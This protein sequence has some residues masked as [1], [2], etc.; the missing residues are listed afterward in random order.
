MDLRISAFRRTLAI[1][2]IYLAVAA[3]VLDAAMFNSALPVVTRVLEVE[4][5]DAIWVVNGY[6]A[7]ILVTLLFFSVIAE[8][9][10][11]KRVFITGLLIFIIASVVSSLSCS[12]LE[13]AMARGLLGVGASALTSI[14]LAMIQGFYPSCFA[15]RAFGFSACVVGLSMSVGPVLASIVLDAWSWTYLFS[16]N[17][18]IA[19]LALVLASWALPCTKPGLQRPS[20]FWTLLCIPAFSRAIAVSILAYASQGMSFTALPFVLYFSLSRSTAELGFVMMLWSLMA[21][22]TAPMSAR[23]SESTYPCLLRLG[24][25]LMSFGQGFIAFLPPYATLIHMAWCIALA[26]AGFGLFQVPNIC[27]LL[28]RVPESLIRSASGM[29][30]TS[31]MLGQLVGSAAVSIFFYAW[32]QDAPLIALGVACGLSALACGQSFF[33]TGKS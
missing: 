15:G 4:A 11:T 33:N 23:L 10:G 26:A 12:L 5:A 16:I 27:I 18:P 25:V 19:T 32:D 7:A 20:A 2:A 29:I 1:T 30:A 6:Q 28:R 17:L 3:V 24:L 13:L 14:N 8:R 9:V 22:V 31:R 21:A